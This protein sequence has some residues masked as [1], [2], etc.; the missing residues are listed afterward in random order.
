MV[1]ERERWAVLDSKMRSV[2]VVPYHWVLL[3]LKSVMRCGARRTQQI[4]R[5]T[6][7]TFSDGRRK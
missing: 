4:V 2:R 3:Y 6:W 7:E 1:P 5:V